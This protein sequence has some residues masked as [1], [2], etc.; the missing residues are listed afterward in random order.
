LQN[1]VNH[2]TFD[3]ILRLWG[4]LQACLFEYGFHISSYKKNMHETYICTQCVCKCE[5]MCKNVWWTLSCRNV[6]R[7][8]DEEKYEIREREIL[9]LSQLYFLFLSCVLRHSKSIKDHVTCNWKKIAIMCFTSFFFSLPVFLRRFKGRKR[10]DNGW[11]Q[12]IKGW[13]GERKKSCEK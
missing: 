1:S 4:N 9:N 6:W 2:K 3:R 11:E 13:T 7:K 10:K 5:C 8:K 12:N